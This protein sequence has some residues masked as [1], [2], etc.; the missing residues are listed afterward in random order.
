M[1]AGKEVVIFFYL[2]LDLIFIFL[3][4]LRLSR[5]EILELKLFV[6]YIVLVEFLVFLLE[7]VE[8]SGGCSVDIYIFFSFVFNVI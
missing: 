3:S 1:G 5:P 7:N 4:A 2:G 8:R 6:V